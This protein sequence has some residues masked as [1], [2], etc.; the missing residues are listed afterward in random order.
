MKM[1]AAWRCVAPGEWNYEVPA[2][3]VLGELVRV[4]PGRWR[5]VDR[6]GLSPVILGVFTRRAA[7]AE[8]IKAVQ[9]SPLIKRLFRADSTTH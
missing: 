5:A 6:C 2:Q 4:A 8:L 3:L 9:A 1:R 7:A